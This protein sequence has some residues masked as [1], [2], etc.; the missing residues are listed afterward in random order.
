MFD[1]YVVLMESIIENQGS[2]WYT[3][4]DDMPYSIDYDGRGIYFRSRKTLINF[5]I[6]RKWNIPELFNGQEITDSLRVTGNWGDIRYFC[7]ACGQP[8]SCYD[9]CCRHC[10]HKIQG[11]NEDE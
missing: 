1:F 5:L 6:K 8:V 9:I 4:A 11:R 2:L 7:K 3:P 10:G